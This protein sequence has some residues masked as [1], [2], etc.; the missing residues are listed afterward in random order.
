MSE[1]DISPDDMYA[2]FTAFSTTHTEVLRQMNHLS[3][4]ESTA[5]PNG[6]DTVDSYGF[7]KGRDVIWAIAHVSGMYVA[8]RVRRMDLALALPQGDP[9]YADILT[10][11]PHS[12]RTFD[13]DSEANR[14]VSFEISSTKMI[15]ELDED[16]FLRHEAALAKK[17]VDD[18]I[19]HEGDREPQ[20]VTSNHR[21]PSHVHSDHTRD[22]AR[23]F[24]DLRIV[25]RYVGDDISEREALAGRHQV[26][27]LHDAVWNIVESI[28]K[29]R[30][31]GAGPKH[32]SGQRRLTDKWI[33]MLPNGNIITINSIQD[34]R[35]RDH[36]AIIMADYVV[37][38]SILASKNDVVLNPSFLIEICDTD[39]QVLDSYLLNGR[40]L[41]VLNIDVQSGVLD[42]SVY[43][44]QTENQDGLQ[45]LAS[46]RMREMIAS[47]HYLDGREAAS[48]AELLGDTCTFMML[49]KLTKA[50]HETVQLDD[51]FISEVLNAQ[52][53]YSDLHP[54]I[55]EVVNRI[56]DPRL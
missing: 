31:S 36:P 18:F 3:E 15:V 11:R 38:P 41:T 32:T 1:Q 20:L 14:T 28:D 56:V 17:G 8:S 42:E 54:D 10:L 6:Q 30:I 39:E 23:D 47:A 49:F 55:S 21:L 12:T 29:D 9:Y 24:I 27:E 35:K 40:K 43:P 53:R 2:R 5:P 52:E 13:V 37:P 22:M 16:I 25:D 48:L 45:K 7:F 4:G 19:R 34:N 26:I 33:T 51:V 44:E 46:H 50:G